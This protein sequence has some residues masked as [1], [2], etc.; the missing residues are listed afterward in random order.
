M[1][2][3]YTQNS[4]S[5]TCKMLVYCETRD[6]TEDHVGRGGSRHSCTHKHTHT[7]TYI[8]TQ[9][10][11][12]EDSNVYIRMKTKAAEQ[13]G[14]LVN[15]WKLPREATESEVVG[16]IEG[17]NQ[18]PTIHAILLQLPLDSIN[19]ISAERCTNAIAVEKVCIS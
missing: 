8:H 17:L 15:H 11:G 4:H 18:D 16:A 2:R 6:H 12:R 5:C 9:V 19:Q 1:K 10:G 13:V 7:Q 14:I 3:A